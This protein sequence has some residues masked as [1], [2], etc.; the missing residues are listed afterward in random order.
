MDMMKVSAHINDGFE[1]LD[2]VVLRGHEL[3]VHKLSPLE[4]LGGAF[5]FTLLRTW[6]TTSGGTIRTLHVRYM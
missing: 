6:D 5:L 1:V 3:L 4:E 2:V